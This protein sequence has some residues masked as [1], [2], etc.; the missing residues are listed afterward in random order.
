MWEISIIA[1]SQII[2]G[3]ILLLSKKKESS[4]YILIIWLLILSLPFLNSILN[5]LEI[6]ASILST[7]L[8]QSF[9]LLHGPL[10]YIYLKELINKTKKKNK[11]WIHFLIFIIFYIIFIISPSQ[12]EPGGPNR[13]I[14]ITNHRFFILKY[15]GIINVAIFLFYGILSIISLYTHKITIKEIF[16]HEKS[17]ITLLWINLLP[18][19][20]VVITS[21]IIFFENSSF[22]NY[23][24]IETLHL[25]MFHFFSLYLI[26]FGLKQKPIYP[27]REKT[28][29]E[30]KQTII[31][32]KQKKSD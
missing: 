7:T 11:Y 3:I 29:L 17:E 23:I 1:I 6:S 24:Q 32:D 22:R 27:K 5:Q 21:I 14:L 10:L 13:E 25:L 2:F 18:I 12:I 26:F 28:N 8:N 19:I 4:D 31:I 15:F 20:F 16:S 30:I 9:T